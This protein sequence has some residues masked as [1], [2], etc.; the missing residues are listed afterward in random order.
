MW[1]YKKYRSDLVRSL[2]QVLDR[3]NYAVKGLER[4]NKRKEVRCFVFVIRSFI[5][6]SSVRVA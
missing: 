2:Y 5:K 1:F 3:M 4:E 6:G